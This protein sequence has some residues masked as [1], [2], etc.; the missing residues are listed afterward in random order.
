VIVVSLD[1]T[2][3]GA[4][5]WEG[6]TALSELARRGARAERLIPVFPT[7]TFPNHVT[8]ATGVVPEIHGI[9]GNV[10]RDPE[11][12]LYRYEDDPTWIEVEPIWAWAARHGVVSA[13]FHWVGS[14]GPW[15]NGYGPR[16]WK[17][18]DA[19][20]PEIEKTAQILAWLD[21]PDA[22]ERPRLVVTYFRGADRAGHHHGP[23]SAEA[24]RALAEQNGAL[25]RLIEGLDARGAWPSTTLLV[26]SDHGMAGVRRN[27]DLDAALRREGVAADVLGGGGVVLLSLREGAA[28]EAALDIARGLGL[29]AFS[30]GEA[31]PG[32]RVGHVR[33]GDALVL[34]PPGTAIARSAH[35][36]E[37]KPA[38]RGAHG[39]R[40]EV[41]EM[42]A[43]FLAAG[44]GAVPGSRLGDM[45]MVD[46]A[47]T[48][49]ALLGLP[50][51]DWMEGRP[52]GALMPA[53][54]GGSHR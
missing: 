47:P 43:L 9:T 21:L 51:P 37:G 12:G 3:P 15:R 33:F 13:A 5:E 23:E 14:Q 11:R 7:N 18:F 42:G 6:S 34:A 50:V 45:R 40:P 46:V 4:V 39:Y 38:M 27:V 31:P 24:R 48:V 17:A 41:S 53:D 1:G 10:F 2:P 35:D 25:L 28:L 20:T 44:R 54:A 32:L 36:E 8:L 19:S 52:I 26:L 22:S 30:R 16:H 49:L 29:D